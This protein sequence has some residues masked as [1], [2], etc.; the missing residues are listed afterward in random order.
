MEGEAF[1]SRTAR[2][3]IAPPSAYAIL[4]EPPR[5][6]FPFLSRE[7]RTPLWQ[8]WLWTVLQDRRYFAVLLEFDLDLLAAARLDPCRHCGGR[9]YRGDYERKG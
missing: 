1:L 9:L 2:G 5:G 6:V 8:I 3:G 4:I 7:R